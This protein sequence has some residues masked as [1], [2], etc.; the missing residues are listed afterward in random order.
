MEQNTKFERWVFS[1]A[2]PVAV[3]I[4]SSVGTLIVTK[5]FGTSPQTDALTAALADPHLSTKDRLELLAAIKALDEPFWSTLRTLALAVAMPLTPI[6]IQVANW[7]GR[8]P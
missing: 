3:A 8:R 2:V 6:G 4:I 5:L 1:A 7:I